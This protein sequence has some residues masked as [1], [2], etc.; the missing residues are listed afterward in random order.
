ML[1][2]DAHYHRVEGVMCYCGGMYTI[3]EGELLWRDVGLCVKLYYYDLTYPF[4]QLHG[5]ISFIIM[6]CFCSYRLSKELQQKDQ[7]IESL[8]T[9][10]QLRPETPSSCRALSETTDQSDRTSFVS[11]E[12]GSNEELELCSEGDAG[13]EYA[14]DRQGD[15]S[16]PLKRATGNQDNP[17]RK[18]FIWSSFDL[19]IISCMYTCIGGGKYW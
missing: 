2:G 10:L 11:D 14:M 12:R 13:S 4:Q 16:C 17:P 6:V 5:G 3:I 9:K 8:H 18:A 7:I 1:W 15:R 19:I